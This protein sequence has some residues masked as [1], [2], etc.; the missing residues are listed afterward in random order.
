MRNGAAGWSIL[1]TTADPLA[2]DHRHCAGP[3]M[4]ATPRREVG[5]D[6]SEHAAHETATTGAQAAPVPRGRTRSGSLW[7]GPL[8][9]GGM[10]M[11]LLG[12]FNAIEGLVALFNDEYYITTPQGLLVFDV[13]AWGW[14]HLIIGIAVVAVAI[15]I[16]I[17]ATWARMCGVIVCGIYALARLVFLSA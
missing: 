1:Y 12:A 6:M 8:Y 7:L 2:D 13:T 9:V 17:G 14:I 10:V 4:T 5:R 15:G 3:A 11:F 16:F